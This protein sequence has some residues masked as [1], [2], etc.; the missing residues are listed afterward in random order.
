MTSK[1]PHEMTP[2]EIAEFTLSVA[3]LAEWFEL[4]SERVRQLVKLGCFEQREDGRIPLQRA[5]LNYERLLTH[6]ARWFASEF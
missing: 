6:G 5:L 2:A 1:R 3:E 4:S